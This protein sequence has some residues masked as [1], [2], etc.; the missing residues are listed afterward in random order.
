M[1]PGG[2]EGLDRSKPADGPIGPGAGEA[3]PG[4][5]VVLGVG[6]LLLSDE[7]VG[8]TTVAY[9]QERWRFPAHVEV[10]DGATAG[11]E[12][13]NVFGDAAQLLV[14]DAVFGGAE[15]GAI[16]RFNLDEVPSGVRYRTSIH[17]ITFIDAWNMA[18]LLGP[19]P[20]VTIV[21]VEPE[22]ISTP[23][24]GLTSSIEARL[25]DVEEVVL[26]ELARLGVVPERH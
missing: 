23:H 8:P 2:E 7:G 12:L 15:P 20:E 22:D 19:A 4:R 11:L 17:Q 9:L 13:I 14:I 6:N 3:A 21:G 25:P 24:V 5:I 1:N 16:Y 10:V 18:R 26:G